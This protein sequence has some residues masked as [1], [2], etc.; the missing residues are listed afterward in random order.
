MGL[1]DY[2]QEGEE[3]SANL[4]SIYKDLNRLYFNGSLP[5]IKLRWSGKLK[6]AVGQAYVLYIQSGRKPRKRSAAQ[7]RFLDEI[8]V[9]NNIELHM[10]S[11]EIRMSKAYDLSMNDIKA[12]MLHE[13]VHILLYTQKK[14][15]G[16]HGTAEFDGWIKKLRDLSGLNVPL[17]ESNFKKSPKLAAKEGIIALIYGN[18]VNKV[19]VA[20]YSKNAVIKDWLG[21]ASILTKHISY[22]SKVRKIEMYKITHPIVASTGSKRS[23]KGLSW[24]WEDESI[25]KEIGTKGTLFFVA[26]K[27]GGWLV[28]KKIG[29]SITN[30]NNTPLIFD[31]KGKWINQSD[32]M[33]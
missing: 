10:S 20:G 27:E 17:L 1:Q 28:P 11:L 4:K 25:I 26:S 30:L 18:Q 12:V 21:M 22:S 7:N 14:L 19:G 5:S 8:P 9:Q 2:L 31:P 29:I 15:G 16:H 23:F 32:V 24:T 33:K 3:G 13:M 6:K